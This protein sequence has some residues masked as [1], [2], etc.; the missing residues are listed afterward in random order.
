MRAAHD[1][2]QETLIH[3]HFKILYVRPIRSNPA[4]QK[5]HAKEDRFTHNNIKDMR[6]YKG[7]ESV[8]N[9]YKSKDATST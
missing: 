8:S 6:T 5:Y 1:R 9:S 4:Q 3:K 2:S 7:Y